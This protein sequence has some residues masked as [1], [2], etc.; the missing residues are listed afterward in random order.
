MKKKVG[1]M[2]DE[3]LIFKAKNVALSQKQPF[4]KLLEDALKL[5]LLTLEGKNKS[6]KEDITKST[7][8][9]MSISKALLD[10]IMEEEGVYES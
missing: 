9:A 4:S 10:T 8:G 5:Y 2:L 1:T 3:D 7:Q 6:K